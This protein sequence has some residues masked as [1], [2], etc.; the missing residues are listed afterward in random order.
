MIE[1]IHSIDSIASIP[2][3]WAT[4]LSKATAAFYGHMSFLDHIDVQ[5]IAINIIISRVSNNHLSSD[6]AVANTVHLRCFLPTLLMLEL[7]SPRQTHP[8]KAPCIH[9]L[10]YLMAKGVR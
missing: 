10:L 8:D 3:P 6:N 4:E 9:Q 1:C 7:D 5:Y 2:K